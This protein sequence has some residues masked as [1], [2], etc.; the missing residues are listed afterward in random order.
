MNLAQGTVVQ[1]DN[2][3]GRIG[4]IER[5][6]SRMAKNFER[7]TRELKELKHM[8]ADGRLNFRRLSLKG[9]KDG[10]KNVGH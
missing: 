4:D 1:L 10:E 3:V 8:Q 5:A 7:V 2:A 9:K 6:M